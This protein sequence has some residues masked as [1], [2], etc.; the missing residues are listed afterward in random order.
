MASGLGKQSHTSLGRA[1]TLESDSP[2]HTAEWLGGESL[3]VWNE[4]V[5]VEWETSVSNTVKDTVRGS[6][7]HPR[8][9]ADPGEP[10]LPLKTP[11]WTG[12]LTPLYLRGLLFPETPNP[13]SLCSS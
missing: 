12:R 3:F 10:H 5:G 4:A 8:F 1:L 11:S 13:G 2:E 7:P 9:R 6:K